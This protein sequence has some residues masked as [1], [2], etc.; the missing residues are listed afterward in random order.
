MSQALTEHLFN[1][2]PTRNKLR[3]LSECARWAASRPLSHRKSVYSNME[4]YDAVVTLGAENSLASFVTKEDKKFLNPTDMEFLVLR[5]AAHQYFYNLTC[6]TDVYLYNQFLRDSGE[7]CHK[8]LFNEFGFWG[9][10]INRITE[11]LS[12]RGCKSALYNYDS[13][14][15]A[16]NLVDDVLKTLESAMQFNLFPCRLMVNV[17]VVGRFQTRDDYMDIFENGVHRFFPEFSIKDVPSLR[18]L[19]S[20][21]SGRQKMSYISFDR[22]EAA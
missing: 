5:G 11:D 14:R 20:D 7:F 17:L 12:N 22:K 10:E 19:S 6:E 2:L 13:Q 4:K 15:F 3:V 21:D 18:R 16:H 1:S 8:N 9:N